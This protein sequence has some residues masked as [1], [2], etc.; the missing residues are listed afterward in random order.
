RGRHDT[1]NRSVA[2]QNPTI[3]KLIGGSWSIHGAASRLRQVSLA[4]RECEELLSEHAK[5]T[6]D[7]PAVFHR[8]AQQCPYHQSRGSNERSH[9]PLPRRVQTADKSPWPPQQSQHRQR[10]HQNHPWVSE[11]VRDSDAHQTLNHS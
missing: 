1:S 4:L 9:R 7:L 6:P 8:V 10:K 5:A 3:T 11:V 2:L